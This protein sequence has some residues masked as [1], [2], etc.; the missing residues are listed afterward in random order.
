MN[1]ETLNYACNWESRKICADMHMQCD[2]GSNRSKGKSIVGS[3]IF[4]VFRKITSAYYTQISRKTMPL[5]INNVQ[6]KVFE[7]IVV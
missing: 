4:E 7:T 6:V 5:L 1:I 3:S 2:Y